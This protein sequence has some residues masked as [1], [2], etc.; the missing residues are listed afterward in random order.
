MN[1]ILAILV[2]EFIRPNIIWLWYY[3]IKLFSK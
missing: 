3:I 1:L 2:Y